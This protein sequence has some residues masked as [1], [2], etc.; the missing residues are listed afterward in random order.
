M[1]NKT[2]E[3]IA[4]VLMDASPT[5]RVEHLT[6]KICAIVEAEK[7]TESIAEEPLAVFCYSRGWDVE[8]ITY[9]SIGWII[10]I[11]AFRHIDFK[12]MAKV[13]RAPTYAAAEAKARAYLN[14][15]ADKKGDL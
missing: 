10:R 12:N 3:S 2:K 4:D 9:R 5:D 6:A 8:D 13:F 11:S 15:L 14:G 1:T 7:A